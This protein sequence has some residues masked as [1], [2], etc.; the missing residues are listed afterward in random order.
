MAMPGVF[1]THLIP[2]ALALPQA[3][4]ARWILVLPV[5]PV[6][7]SNYVHRT[8]ISDYVRNAC[9]PTFQ[10]RSSQSSLQYIEK[11]TRVITFDDGIAWYSGVR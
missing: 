3:S 4:Q 1:Q 10:D 11:R 5:T 9:T 7:I 6:Q 2:T 8:Q